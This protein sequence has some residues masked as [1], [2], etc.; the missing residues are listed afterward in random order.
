MLC[1]RM[2]LPTASSPLRICFKICTALLRG[3]RQ[4]S[5]H[6]GSGGKALKLKINGKLLTVFCSFGLQLNAFPLML[7]TGCGGL[8]NGTPG[9]AN[10]AENSSH[11]YL[12]RASEVQTIVGAFD[13]KFKPRTARGK[14]F[15]ARAADFLNYRVKWGMICIM[16]RRGDI[17]MS[18]IGG[19]VHTDK[20]WDASWDDH[21]DL[22]GP[23]RNSAAINC[24]SV[25][26][27]VT[28][29]HYFNVHDGVRTN[30]AFDW[31]VEHNWGEY[32]RDDGIEN[33][34]LH[35][36]RLYD[37]L[38]D[39]CYTGISTRPSSDDTYTKG[40]GELVELDRVLLRLQAMPYPYKWETKEGVIGADGKPYTGSGIPYGQ[41]NFFK[42]TSANRNPHFSIRNSVFLA[43]H[44]TEASN[45]DFPPESLIDVCENNIIIWL[46][47][48]PYPGK[49]PTRKFPNGFKIITGQEGRDLW[50]SK[51]IDWHS[52]H[53]NVGA[54]RKP[55]SPGS[56]VFPKVF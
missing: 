21:K 13:E 4:A 12:E 10:V 52:R 43:A 23:T 18:W 48:G 53:P 38:F 41:G 56:L 16:G 7:L 29:L 35:S 51:V 2:S 27:T 3:R 39:G 26:M 42:L 19:Y 17:G 32:V 49:L 50:V 44:L 5:F 31:V 1:M 6:G 47:P 24:A 11:A 28:D 54:N 33:D 25:G 36:G 34:H 20:P 46:G 14:A 22:D 55:S 37:S 40:A 45:L 8:N 30:D 15:D 9:T